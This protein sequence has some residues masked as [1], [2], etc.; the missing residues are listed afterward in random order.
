[1]ENQ[2]YEIYTDA[3]FDDETKIGTYSI[4]IT[5]DK[6][7]IK[8]F[9]KECKVNLDGSAEC[10][11]FAMFQAMNIIEGSLINRNENQDFLLYTDFNG[12]RDFFLLGKKKVKTFKK[13][14]ELKNRMRKT[15]K[16]IKENLNYGCSFEIKWISRENNK[17]AHQYAYRAF[18]RYKKNI[19]LFDSRAL[20]SVLEKSDAKRYK[21]FIYL[22]LIK[23]E[24]KIILKTQK[25]ISKALEFSI[26]CINKIFKELIKLKMLKKIRNGKY[27]LLL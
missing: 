9:G 22:Y 16:R 14:G 10:E 21:V 12:A 19:S 4:V 2:L 17:A 24:E 1:M 18:K 26:S 25:E 15:F 27:Q 23:N 13:N 7:I 6:K 11:I 3:S 8:A 20:E 5:K